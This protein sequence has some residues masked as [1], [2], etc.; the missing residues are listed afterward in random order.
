MQYFANL[1][2]QTTPPNMLVARQ[3][4]TISTWMV[5]SILPIHLPNLCYM[6]NHISDGAL[7]CNIGVGWLNSALRLV[8]NHV[9]NLWWYLLQFE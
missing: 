1:L 7:G 9:T 4:N 8:I 5:L 3:L 6:L 2:N